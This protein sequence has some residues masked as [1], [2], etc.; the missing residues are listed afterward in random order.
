MKGV[1][2]QCGRPIT[3]ANA[4]THDEC[5]ARAIAAD[6]FAERDLGDR[7]AATMALLIGKGFG[8]NAHW[9]RH[10]G[11]AAPGAWY[12][13]LESLAEDLCRDKRGQVE[14]LDYLVSLEAPE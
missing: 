9:Q 4:R 5:L 3:K 13:A 12:A 10:Y 11:D 2:S 8:C 14:A 1:C 7:A 6:A